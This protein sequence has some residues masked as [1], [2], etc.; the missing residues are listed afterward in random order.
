MLE[1]RAV[2]GADVEDGFGFRIFCETI[3]HVCGNLVEMVRKRARDAGEIRVIAEHGFFRHCVIELRRVAI[4]APNHPQ[5][6]ARLSSNF[7]GFEK[8]IAPGLLAPNRW[9]IPVR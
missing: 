5:R 4:T 1:L 9:P 3:V 7:F 2:V 6:I 8:M